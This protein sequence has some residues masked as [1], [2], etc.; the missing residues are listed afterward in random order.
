MNISQPFARCGFCLVAACAL[1]ARPTAAQES[2]EKSVVVKESDES[3]SI[4]DIVVDL[5]GGESASET[6]QPVPEVATTPPPV[7]V[8]VNAVRQTPTPSSAEK[9]D[10]KVEIQTTYADAVREAQL[11]NRPVL[12]VLGAEWCVWCRKLEAELATPAAESI[13]KEWVVVNV[14]VDDEPEVATRLQASALP[15]LRVLGPFQALVASREGYVEL[16]ELKQWLAE[17][18]ASA[19]P[20]LH[21]VLYDTAAPDKAAVDQ[22]I[23]LLSQSSPMVRAAAMERLAA[24]PRHATGAVV[25]TLKT[26]RLVQQLCATEVLRRWSAPVGSLDPWQPETLDGDDFSKLVDWSRAQID[27]EIP[28]ESI[29]DAT[30]SERA[31]APPASDSEL[32]NDLVERLIAADPSDRPSIIAQ[33]LSTGAPLAVVARS[34]LAQEEFLGDAAR[35]A[36]REL[37]YN[38]LASGQLRLEQSGVITALARLDSETHRQA[39]AT[40]LDSAQIIDQPLTDELV[41]DADPLIRELSVRALG[42]LGLLTSGDRIQHLLTDTSP[43]VRTAV[44]RA[45]TEHPSEQA[46]EA[47]CTYLQH[48]TDEDLLVHGAKCLGQLARQPKALDTLALLARNSSWRVRATAVEAAGQTINN[49]PPNGW[50]SPDSPAVP[51]ALASAIVAAAFED[52]AFVAERAAALLPTLLNSGVV[53]EQALETIAKS[54][55]EHPEKLDSLGGS[56]RTARIRVPAIRQQSYPALVNVAK[57]WL[58]QDDPKNIERAAILLS[59][60]DAPALN[61]RLGSLIAS[62]ERSMRMAGLRAAIDSVENY[63]RTTIEAAVRAWRVK[64]DEAHP[65]RQPAIEPWYDA[66]NAEST[67]SE[68]ATAATPTAP[69]KPRAQVAETGESSPRPLDAVTDLF[70]GGPTT[71]AA[72]SRPQPSAL[73]AASE[74]FGDFQDAPRSKAIA[75]AGQPTKVDVAALALPSKWMEQWQGGQTQNRPSWLI[76][77]EE[78]TQALLESSDP[79]ERAAALALWLM[80]GH[81]DRTSELLA[82]IDP[83]RTSDDSKQLFVDP[84]QL[85]SWLPS[86][87]RLVQCNALVN[88]HAGDAERIIAILDQITVVDDPQVAVWLYESLAQEPYSEPKL[89]QELAGTLLRSLVGF[90]AETLPASLSPSDFQYGSEAPYR[91]TRANTLFAVP[92]RIAAC[93][94]LRERYRTG[95]NDRQRAIALAAVARL[96]HKT[97]V[98]AALG[99]IDEAEVDGELLQTALTIVLNDAAVPSVER[100][101]TFVGH[102]VPAVRNAALGLLATPRSQAQQERE[103]FLPSIGETSS[104]LPGFWQSK[105]KTPIKTLQDLLDAE[106]DPAMQS[107]AI[108]L[109]LAAGERAELAALERQLAASHAE[110]TKLTIAA[111]LAKAGRT[112]DEAVKYYEQ[113]Y[114]ESSTPAG[115]GDDR[116]AAALYEILRD[117][118]DQPIIELRR[119]M[120]NEK[121]SRLFNDNTAT[122]DVF[123]AP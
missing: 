72:S 15:A 119:R 62:N 105:Q 9:R 47:L 106:S 113:V 16:A 118:G 73:D 81:T 86:D 92:G 108:L 60:F 34:R 79:E 97:A 50:G 32:L 18:R 123:G 30:H 59:R 3:N 49:R 22:L 115:G 51:E 5:F 83:S 65:R 20:A 21:K 77:C 61:D 67:A 52:D 78:P 71:P 12:A 27:S 33:L 101:M 64:S 100:A 103:P 55:A 44:L 95:S 69:N 109:L 43:N 96:D 75:L 74:M 93:Q 112:D 85:S 116:I 89:K 35:E 26:G 1:S 19:D 121:G 94:W 11:H 31:A 56:P 40:I 111:A 117:L 37:L 45:L 110:L 48:E 104:V 63:R 58:T 41:R 6:V 76:A 68:T 91:V 82:R 114:V 53:D 99:A 122:D 46:V 10:T 66:P 90:T 13:L 8:P 87:E 29:A 4:F 2:T 54:L 42:R 17:N 120:R 25:Q 28:A 14:D 70:A 36:L 38:S 102:Q 84:A 88:A 57:K 24:H 80:L 23:S 98:D 107:R 39:A 7:P